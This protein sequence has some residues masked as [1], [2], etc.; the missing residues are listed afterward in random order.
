[1]APFTWTLNSG[2]LPPGLT[3]SSGGVISGTPPV[4]DLDSSGNAKTYSFHGKGDGLPDADR[5]ISDG[6]LLH[7]HQSASRGHLHHS[8]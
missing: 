1:M 7:H 2:T 5:R 4:T 8:S 3:L 6:K